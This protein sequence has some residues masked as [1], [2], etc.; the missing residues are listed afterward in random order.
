MNVLLT[1]A[2]RRNYLVQYFREALS[3]SGS[4]L[5]ADA[6]RSASALSEADKAFVVPPV[7]HAEYVDSIRNICCR[8]GVRLLVPIN[9]LELPT[10]AASRDRFIRSG[11]LPV[12]SSVER[13]DLCADKLATVEFLRESRLDFPKTYDSLPRALDAVAGGRLAFPVVIKPRW[14]TASIGIEYAN[15][16]EELEF[17]HRWVKSH[18]ARSF[19]AGV[20]CDPEHDVLIQ[21]KLDGQEYGLDVVND[22][23]GRYITTFARRKLAMRAGETDRAITVVDARL[24]ALGATI[25]SSLGHVGNLDCDVFDVGGVYHVLEMNPRFGGGYPFSHTAGA[26]LPAALIAWANGR[27]PNP[28]W[29]RIRPNI[30]VS[31]CDRLVVTCD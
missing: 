26:N 21:E 11:V 4:I 7:A 22:L 28:D 31:K 6:N 13:I 9:D 14:G 24:E 15:S 12:I 20:G 16:R 1:C 27:Q 19:L 29:L 10:L 25:G 5:A 8:H 18:L 30:V 17:G 3:G 23:D 2:G